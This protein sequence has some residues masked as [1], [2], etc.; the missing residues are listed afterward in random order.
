[1]YILKLC[2]WATTWVTSFTTFKVNMMMAPRK[3]AIEVLLLEAYSSS[4][5]YPA[6][7]F[8]GQHVEHVCKKMPQNRTA[9]PLDSDHNIDDT[10][11]K[12][13]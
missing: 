11:F 6:S 4:C 2:V 5:Q 1:M 3:F 8:A 13:V 10:S 7:H 12:D 9:S